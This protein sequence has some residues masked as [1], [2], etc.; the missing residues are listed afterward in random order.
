MKVAMTIAPIYDANSNLDGYVATGRDVTNE[1]KLEMRLRQSEKLSSLGT[2][3]GGI[4]HDF[5][6]LLVPIL[7]YADLLRRDGD[8]QVRKYI[9]GIID[10]SERARELVRRILIFGRGGTGTLEPL[11]LRF[12]VG[13]ATPLL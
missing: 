4:A 12:E 2:L 9:E 6:N 5:N 3:A 8:D 1:E 10:A 7:G 13:D 11:D